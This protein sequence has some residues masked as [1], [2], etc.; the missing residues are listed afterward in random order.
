MSDIIT[1]SDTTLDAVLS[2]NESPVLLD[3]WA[4]W[5]QPCLAIAPT[6]KNLAYQAGRAVTVVKLDVERYPDAMQRFGV[7]G[8]PTLLLFK[9]GKLASRQMGALTLSELKQWLQSEGITLDNP[10]AA[11]LRTDASWPAFYGDPSLHAFL[12]QR[13]TQHVAAGQVVRFGTPYWVDD[14]G[15]ISA[16]LA[17]HESM[18]VFE[19]VTGLPAAV[20][21]ILESVPFLTPQQAEALFEV[22][23]PDKDVWAVPLQWVRFL[24]SDACQPWSDWLQ[25]PQLDALRKQWLALTDRYLSGQAVPAHDWEP[26]RQYTSAWK[27]EPDATQ[28]LENALVDILAALSPAPVAAAETWQTLR[29]PIN[30]ILWQI[31][32]IDA[33]WTPAERAVPAKRDLWFKAQEDLMSDQAPANEQFN[34]WQ[35]QWQEENADFAAKEVGFYQT[36]DARLA[37][38][39][40]PL[41]AHL[42]TLLRQSP[43]FLPPEDL[44]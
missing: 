40:Q 34:A 21:V 13:L 28:E 33:G 31:A 10:P 19:R 15:T 8:I 35:T 42:L 20:A 17:H 26:V 25:A 24:L 44:D 29:D 14:R 22:L 6:L 36:V 41:Q 30:A 9:H 27:A 38:L 16:T 43:R 4:P 32:Q 39:E 11:S 2:Q 18:T 7:R 12:A 5:C 37:V 23:T 1:A 3:L